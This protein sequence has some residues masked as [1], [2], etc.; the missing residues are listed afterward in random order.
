[1]RW[2]KRYWNLNVKV[3]SA[4]RPY[5]VPIIIMFAAIAYIIATLVEVMKW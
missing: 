4:I 2:L 3:W 1:M 5:G